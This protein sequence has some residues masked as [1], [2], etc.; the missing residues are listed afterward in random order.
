MIISKFMKIISLNKDTEYQTL[1]EAVIVLKNSGAI[2]APTDTIY[3]LLAD[4]TDKTAIKKI[5]ALKARP[6]NKPTPI[7]IDS[8]KMLDEV[9]YVKNRKITEFLEKV[10]PGKTTCVLPSRGWMPLEVRGGG[11]NI[12]V[13]MP[14]NDFLISLTK[15]LGKPITAT[16]ANISGRYG[17]SRIKDVI[18]EFQHLPLQPDLIIDAGDLPESKPSTVIDL[19]KEPPEIIR[20]GAIPKSEILSLISE[21]RSS[22]IC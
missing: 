5:F 9:A 16:S 20:E 2:V 14:D 12:G 18:N 22:E 4:A 15:G 3:G 21:Q 10:W 13:R 8:F 17:Y 19:T 1:L 7:F 11:L 6:D